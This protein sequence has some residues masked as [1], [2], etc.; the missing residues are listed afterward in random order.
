MRVIQLSQNYICFIDDEDYSMI[1]PYGW[2]VALSKNSNKL[3]ARNRKL[4]LMHRYL[5]KIESEY[6]I[7][8]KQ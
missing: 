8:L 3:Y 4:G 7:H 5:L 1:Q 2:H 6:G